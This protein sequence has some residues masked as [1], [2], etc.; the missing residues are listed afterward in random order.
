[1]N[2][3]PTYKDPFYY[4]VEVEQ[5]Y[6]HWSWLT[7][8]SNVTSTNFEIKTNRR[9]AS[10]RCKVFPLF[11]FVSLTLL[12][13]STREKHLCNVIAFVCLVLLALKLNRKVI[14]HATTVAAKCES[15]LFRHELSL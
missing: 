14:R 10:K 15:L 2:H 1:M 8:T 7:P 13:L 12:V 4:V 5:K 3:D 11:T 9:L 6:P